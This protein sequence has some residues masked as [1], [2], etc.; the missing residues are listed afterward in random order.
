[1]SYNILNILRNHSQI[2]NS[3][4]TT[5]PTK[6]HTSAS[7]RNRIFENMMKNVY[8]VFRHRTKPHPKR[9]SYETTRRVN[10]VTIIDED[11]D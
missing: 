3:A 5:Y 8:S 9:K 7:V 10:R 11:S 6:P 4:N 2:H 1:M